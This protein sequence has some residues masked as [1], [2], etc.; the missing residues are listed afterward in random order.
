MFLKILTQYK[1]FDNKF[2]I[3]HGILHVMSTLRASVALY[4]HDH[5]AAHIGLQSAK[6]QFWHQKIVFFSQTQVDSNVLCE[7]MHV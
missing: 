7:N 2:K 6:K 4:E 3:N 1:L 5:S